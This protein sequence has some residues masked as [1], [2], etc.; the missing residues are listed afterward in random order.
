MPLDVRVGERIVTLPMADGHGSIALPAGATYT[1]DP[2]SKILRREERF[3]VFQRYQE[4][5][6]KAKAGT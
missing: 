1:L 3:E 6:Q 2:H 5:Q 4:R